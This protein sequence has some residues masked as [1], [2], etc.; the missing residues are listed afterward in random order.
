MI[1]STSSVS[2]GRGLNYAGLKADPQKDESDFFGH[3]EPINNRRYGAQVAEGCSSHCGASDEPI[4]NLT[5]VSV[6]F[7]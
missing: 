6:I 2:L 1:H 3:C 7:T 4:S 5:S